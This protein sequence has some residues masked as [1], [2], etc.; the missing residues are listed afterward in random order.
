MARTARDSS[1]ALNQSQGQ[2]HQPPDEDTD[3]HGG[4]PQDKK[5]RPVGPTV[6]GERKG[7]LCDCPLFTHTQNVVKWDPSVLNA[8]GALVD[9]A[10]KQ[11][12]R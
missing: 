9:E 2:P 12:R 8:D 7:G 3:C 10:D 11:A 5:P 4:C 6:P 1:P